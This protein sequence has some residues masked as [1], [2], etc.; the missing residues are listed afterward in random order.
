[1]IN[2][3]AHVGIRLY[4]C[5]G[6]SGALC[7][8]CQSPRAIDAK[9]R[10]VECFDCHTTAPLTDTDLIKIAN[11]LASTVAYMMQVLSAGQVAPVE[12]PPWPPSPQAMAELQ[13]ILGDDGAVMT[14][15]DPAAVHETIRRAV[16]E[17]EA[18]GTA[19]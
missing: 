2:G 10:Q 18:P 15:D 1:M 16:S 3:Y 12:Q 19:A 17:P 6:T 4:D 11:S 9:A 5:V 7:P 14:L 13:Q 8:A